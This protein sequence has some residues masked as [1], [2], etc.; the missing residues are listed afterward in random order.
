[1]FAAIVESFQHFVVPLERLAADQ[2]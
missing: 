2:E 1:M